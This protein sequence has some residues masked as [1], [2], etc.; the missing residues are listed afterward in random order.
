MTDTPRTHKFIRALNAKGIIPDNDFAN[1][2]YQ[3][4]TQLQRAVE[5][6]GHKAG[7]NLHEYRPKDRTHGCSCGWSELKAEIGGK[8]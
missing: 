7:C 2:A 8:L 5:Y 6:G 1:F 3:L 4:E